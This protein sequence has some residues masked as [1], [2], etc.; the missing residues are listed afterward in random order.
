MERRH[1]IFIVLASL[2]LAGQIALRTYFAPPASDADA[3]AEVANDKEA[4]DKEKDADAKQTADAQP[5][6]ADKSA[7]GAAANAAAPT[8]N[9]GEAAPAI[10]ALPAEPVTPRERV[11]IGSADPSATNPYGLLITLDSL[12]ASIERAEISSVKYRDID[13]KSGYLGNLSLVAT[14]KGLRVGVVG[15]GTPAALATSEGMGEQA[16]LQKGDL[17]LAADGNPL[18]MP[19]DLEQYL[20]AKTKPGHTLQ[21]K[22]ER[23][24]DEKSQELLFTA[25][26][27]RYPVSI[28]RPESHSY[29]RKDGSSFDD[30][31]P[32]PN[33]LRMKLDHVL[34]QGVTSG[35]EELR[36]FPSLQSMN[37]TVAKQTADTVEFAADLGESAFAKIGKTGSLRV[38]KRYRLTPH[39]GDHSQ[40]YSLSLEIEFQNT[41]KAVLPLSYRLDGPRGLPLEGSWYSNKLHPEM[42]KMAGARD[43]VWKLKDRN[44]HLVSSSTVHSEAMKAR[45]E[46]KRS[47]DY[48]L[49]E[50]G[51]PSELEYVGVDCQFFSA[52]IKPV[53]SEKQTLVFRDASA[54]PAEPHF[55]LIDPKRVKTMNN[56][57]Q[58][59][60]EIVSIPAGENASHQ[61]DLF[62]GPKDP[63]TLEAYGLHELIEYGWSFAAYPAKVL[64]GVLHLLHA[65]VRNYGLAIILL[66]IIVRL[67]MLPLSLKQ[68]RSTAL[69]QL[70][71]PEIA[72]IKEKYK[73][74]T[75]K[76][77]KA[78]WELYA[79]YKFNPFGGCLLVFIQLPIFIGLYRC[80]SV[81]ID[82]RDAALIPGLEWCSNLAG[83]DALFFW[84]PFT[85]AVISDEFHGYFGPYFNVL[86]IITSSLFIIQQKMFTPPPTDEQSEMQQKVMM[87]MTAFMGIMFFKVPAGLCLYFITSSIWG[88]AERKLLKMPQIEGAIQ[89]SIKK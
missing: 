56:S 89:R 22:V 5:G 27:T 70:L 46:K 23:T 42:W 43:V 81:D 88:I 4:G 79:K 55:E 58:L 57:F 47:Y 24:R 7:E 25:K 74:N 26:L 15:A 82:L 61:Y 1:L 28:I 36:A 40:R 13:E 48:S 37:W 8:V 51:Q 67:G 87:F 20:R 75:E 16:G 9:P 71:Q 41:S 76:L 85:W 53:S 59:A 73:D 39:E 31:R 18:F 69:M 62:L 45:K 64:R 72:K 17:I 34:G 3:A 12:G 38:V 86:P 66:T 78:T 84:K 63:E 11:T 44:H 30:P 54:R 83:P 29:T 80:L 50:N 52:V 65:V 6:A 49:L 19:L 35:E 33:S 2:L 77:N 10:S 32:D 68:A 60:T 14:K 21:L